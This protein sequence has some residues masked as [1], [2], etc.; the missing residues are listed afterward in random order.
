MRWL[1]LCGAALLSCGPDS[2]AGGTESASG[3]SEG[4]TT[5]AST[6]DGIPEAC[7]AP[8][9]T[10]EKLAA[11][12]HTVCALLST[13]GIR[14]WGDNS[15]GQLGLGHTN[16][17]GDDEFPCEGIPGQ[18]VFADVDLSSIGNAACGVSAD[19][20]VI[21]WGENRA[22]Y[23]VDQSE[24]GVTFSCAACSECCLGDDEEVGPEPLPLPAAAN[25]VGVRGSQNCVLTAEGSVY[26]WGMGGSSF[27]VLGRGTLDEVAPEDALLIDLPGAARG[28]A[29]HSANCVIF[30]EAGLAC[31]GQNLY[32][33]IPT[34][35][36]TPATEPSPVQSPYV[37]D[38]DEDILD[39]QTTYGMTCVLL[40]SGGVRC[41][42][43]NIEYSMGHVAN[44]LQSCSE[45]NGESESFC[46]R[47]S[48]CC[49]GDEEPALEVPLVPTAQPFVQL[50][51][52]N[53][54]M[55]QGALL[56]G[57]TA[58][59]EVLCWGQGNGSAI[60][61]PGVDAV[62]NAADAVPVNL[63]GPAKQV[64]AG[65]GFACALMET[66][67]VRCWGSNEDGQLGYGHTETIGD[68]EHPADAGDVPL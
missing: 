22:E 65:D 30:D 11:G 40:A 62:E 52:A 49:L 20:G 51:V 61:V 31:W 67:S 29:L 6:G 3:T 57:L 54:T 12:G 15:S 68:D 4:G 26:C 24:A 7:A 17:I 44:P 37:V 50:T 1:V 27:A 34:N 66:G 10:V 32:A 5:G 19:G 42:G 9:P 60:G 45:S 38:T 14:C 58:E 16:P 48:S 2:G 63:G 39:V 47:G 41:F 56:C 46:E 43:L 8:T 33:N 21:C 18:H 64:V 55:S 35:E 23:G 28:L 36:S 59:G 25:A 13:G 53:A